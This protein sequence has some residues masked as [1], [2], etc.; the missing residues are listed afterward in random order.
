MKNLLCLILICTAC[1]ADLN[2]QDCVPDVQYENE[3]FAIYPLPDPVGSTV[4]SIDT[5]YVGQPYEYTFT[6]VVPDSFT[7]D[8]MT[9]ITTLNL[10]SL[11]INTVSGLPPG[12]TWQ[13]EP[14]DCVFPDQTMGCIKISGTPTSSGDFY[15]VMNTSIDVG[16]NLLLDIPGPIHPGE[17]KIPIS[18]STIIQNTNKPSLEVQVYPNPAGNTLYIQAGQLCGQS[19]A[20]HIFSNDGRLIQQGRGDIANGQ[21][22]SQL[23]VKNLASGVYIFQ[24]TFPAGEY[25]RERFVKF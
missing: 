22:A 11:T 6:V 16:A 25:G 15:I 24:I 3:D 10:K 17:Y 18:P 9:G 8:L 4:S 7:F 20:Y 12:V 2:A 23:D 1:I 13:C 19:L 21:F 14:P 5:G